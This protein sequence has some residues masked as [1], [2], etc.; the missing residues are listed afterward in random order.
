MKKEKLDLLKQ[1]RY[2]KILEDCGYVIINDDTIELK[3]GDIIKVYNS[4]LENLVFN[5]DGGI[6]R[7]VWKSYT[8]NDLPN[9]ELVKYPDSKP[10]NIIEYINMQPKFELQ[11]T[12][13]ISAWIDSNGPVY[14]TPEILNKM[15][16]DNK[17]FVELMNGEYE[18]VSEYNKRQ[19]LNFDGKLNYMGNKSKMPMLTTAEKLD[20]E[21]DST[22][23]QEK[24][25]G[26]LLQVIPRMRSGFYSTTDGV[27][28]LK[29]EYFLEKGEII[30]FS[31]LE[32]A[33]LVLNQDFMKILGVS[34]EIIS[35]R[36]KLKIYE[37][38]QKDFLPRT[39]TR[40]YKI[41][42]DVNVESLNQLQYNI[43]HPQVQDIGHNF[44]RNRVKGRLQ[45]VETEDERISV[46]KVDYQNPAIYGIV[47][48][49]L[50][51]I[52]RRLTREEAIFVHAN[53]VF[54]R[55]R[56]EEE[57]NAKE[58]AK[59]GKDYFRTKM[60]AD[61]AQYYVK[62]QGETEEF[63][64]K[65]YKYYIDNEKAYWNMRKTLGIEYDLEFEDF[66]MMHLIRSERKDNRVIDAEYK[67]KL[68]EGRNSLIDVLDSISKKGGCE[69]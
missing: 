61:L 64:S 4:Q 9:L 68:Q 52:S 51:K 62:K 66:Y 36:K 48:K 10:L 18:N 37:R 54:A 23:I 21:K 67:N 38:E 42:D 28:S 32:Y 31:K 50:R 56:K 17:N 11:A 16:N 58:A 33:F 57:N 15:L 19:I 47:D 7:R 69:K 59:K 63:S 65:A 20:D 6:L 5:K 29:L 41:K 60:I 2:F 46:I 1:F 44:N 12:T 34:E 55:Y 22:E 13:E 40:Y 26:D 53:E 27:S 8:E 45:V 30:D 24:S 35:P 25:R 14:L 49:E 43:Y 39:A 3:K